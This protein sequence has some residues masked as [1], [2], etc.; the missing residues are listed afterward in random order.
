MGKMELQVVDP[1]EDAEEKSAVMNTGEGGV[2]WFAKVSKPQ[3]TLQRLAEAVAECWQVKVDT[4][5]SAEI[6]VCSPEDSP[7]PSSAKRRAGAKITVP[8]GVGFSALALLGRWQGVEWSPKV[9]RRR[10]PTRIDSKKPKKACGV[11][12]I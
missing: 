1:H 9:S 6:V 8:P 12:V 5:R 10:K 2:K 4:I 3:D 11:V 7:M